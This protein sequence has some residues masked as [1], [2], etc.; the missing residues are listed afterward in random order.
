MDDLTREGGGGTGG[1]GEKILGALL[2]SFLEGW[3]EEMSLG[4]G[5]GWKEGGQIP[6]NGQK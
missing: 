4:A 3:P 6:E 1:R 5:N 2:D